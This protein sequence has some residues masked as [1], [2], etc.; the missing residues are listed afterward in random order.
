VASY[1]YVLPVGRGQHFLNRGGVVN[2]VL[3]GWQ[4]N[5]ILTMQSGRVFTPTLSVNASNSAGGAQRPDRIASAVL[6]YGDRTIGRW[7]DTTAFATPVGFAF[8]DSGRNIL[9]GPRLQV[10]DSSLFKNIPINEKVQLQIRIESFNALNHANFALP[11][12]VIG[13]AAAGTISATVGSPR[14]NQAALKLLF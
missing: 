2:A 9:T 14:Q 4:L 10:L 7:F 6:P 5:G 11:N 13:T 1:A 12:A 3:G 8:G